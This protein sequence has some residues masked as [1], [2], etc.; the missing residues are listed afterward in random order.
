MWI[1]SLYLDVSEFKAFEARHAIAFQRARLFL[2][3]MPFERSPAVAAPPDIERQ[4]LLSPVVVLR[5]EGYPV[6][7]PL[8]KN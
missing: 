7:F 1:N 5:Y 8:L 3:G 4:A 2:A 6:Q